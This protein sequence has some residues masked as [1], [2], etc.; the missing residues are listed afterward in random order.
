MNINIVRSLIIITILLLSSL[1]VSA[2]KYIIFTDREFG[3]WALRTAN[4]SNQSHYINKILTINTGDTVEWINMDGYDERISVISEDNLWENESLL[5]GVGKTFDFTF[6]SSG[7][8][9]FRIKESSRLFLNSSNYTEEAKS[10]SNIVYINYT[11]S[12]GTIGT[13]KL[14]RDS[15]KA[16]AEY[17]NRVVEVD[18]YYTKQMTVKV[19]GNM[20]GNGTFPIAKSMQVTPVISSVY[21]YSS[22]KTIVDTSP[23]PKSTITVTPKPI[24]TETPRPYE[25]FQE[26]TLYELAKKWYAIILKSND[27]S[28]T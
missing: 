19:Y 9:T 25:S 15:N 3:F 10:D 27:N 8:Y 21:K 22:N 24:V 18:Q 26:F 16:N 4:I 5:S 14:R 11:K 7:T 2:E 28:Q 17:I 1:P 6:N 13:L 23:K 12:D 20:I